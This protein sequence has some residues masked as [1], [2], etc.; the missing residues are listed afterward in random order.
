[1]DGEAVWC[2]KD[3]RSNF[4]KLHSNAHDDEVCL[5]GFDLLELNSEDY[6]NHPLEKRKAKLEKILARTQGMRFSERLD[7]DGETIFE[8]ACKLGLEGIV[9]KR[10]DFPYRSGRCKSWVRL[11]RV[12]QKSD[13]HAV[14]V[15]AS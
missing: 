6:R 15:F 10:R 8:Q 5:Y 14:A 4:D 2:G 1:V 12:P 11:E 9:S 3:G 7:G 13:C